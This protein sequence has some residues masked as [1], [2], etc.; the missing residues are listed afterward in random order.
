MMSSHLKKLLAL[1]ILV[2]VALFFIRF[3]TSYFVHYARNSASAPAREEAWLSGFV[4][5]SYEKS[6]SNNISKI[7]AV[8]QQLMSNFNLLEVFAKEARL[9]SATN[10]FDADETA[11]RAKVDQHGA[12]IRIEKKEGLKPRRMLQLVI[13]VPE[14][15]FD[16]L[17]S[18]LQQVGTLK[19]LQVAKEDKTEEAKKL[20]VE[21]KSL[22]AYKN[23]LVS[24]RRSNGKVEEFVALESNI[25]EVQ[26]KIEE[27][28]SR[29]GGFTGAESFNNVSFDLGEQSN[30]F[31]HA[32]SYPLRARLLDACI[33]TIKYYLLLLLLGAGVY[34][35][36]WS[37]RTLFPKQGNEHAS[38]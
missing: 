13:R 6:V 17:V 2:F 9:R 22:E 20:L 29:I 14:S 36:L 21:K 37:I 15:K 23:S 25:H 34:L 12:L 35:T 24:L 1:L 26:G 16:G 31:G 5:I 11:V 4:D 3:V 7:A 30:L 10:Q 32:G 18:D 8:P 38:S 19:S 27:L 33:W 28:D